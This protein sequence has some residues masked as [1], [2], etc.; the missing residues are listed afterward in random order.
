[1]RSTRFA[2]P[3]HGIQLDFGGRI[4]KCTVHNT[5]DYG[6]LVG[7]DTLV[8]GN[9]LSVTSSITVNGT[10]NTIDGNSCNNT[11]NCITMT[12]P[13][14]TD[15]LV[16]RNTSVGNIVDYFIGP[17]NTVGPITGDLATA[18]PWANIVVD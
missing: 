12:A 7:S 18:G 10:H 11:G 5:A 4:E 15:N 17:D 9:T 8:R 16:I 1:M 3:A 2:R 6:I 14:A 13:T